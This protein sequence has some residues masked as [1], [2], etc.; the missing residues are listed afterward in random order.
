VVS[1][2]GQKSGYGNCIEVT[3]ANGIITRYAHMSAFR[4]HLGQ[5]VGAGQTIGAIGSTGRSTGPHLHFEVR[6]HDRPIN[7][8]PFWRPLPMF[9]KKTPPASRATLPHRGMTET[10]GNPT[11][12][13]LAAD[14]VVK[15]NLDAQADLH[16]DGRI[17]GDIT[18]AAL[19][20]GEGSEIVGEIRADSARLAGTVR[21]TITV[22]ELVVLRSAR[23]HGDVHYDTLTIEQGAA[24]DGR[25][26]QR[27][28][29]TPAQI[30]GE[31]RL[32]EAK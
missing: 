21:G 30:E 20:Q 15:G 12:S 14:L 18:C 22:G 1:F 27:S 10:M 16:I 19:V 13:V 24:V 2:A 31:A 7:P 28:G 23:I 11:F 25:F 6:V 4:A 9:R 8:R 26:A 17:E 5:N 32:I 3:H 29:S